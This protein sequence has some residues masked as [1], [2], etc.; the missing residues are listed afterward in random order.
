VKWFKRQS[1]VAPLPGNPISSTDRIPHHPPP[2]RYPPP[3]PEAAA[4]AMAKAMAE[5]SNGRGWG[6]R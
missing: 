5:R 2:R 4:E 6:Q 1:P 3:T